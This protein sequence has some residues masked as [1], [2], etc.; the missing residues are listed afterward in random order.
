MMPLSHGSNPAPYESCAFFIRHNPSER[1]FLFFGDVE[2]D[3]LASEP[4]T[5]HVWR[6]AAPKIPHILDTIFIECSWPSGREDKQL[7]GHL[8]PEHLVQELGALALEVT[9]WRASNSNKR[10]A[11]SQ[12]NASFLR[13]RK[14]SIKAKPLSLRGALNGVRIFIIH[15]KEDMQSKYNKPMHEIITEQVKRLMDEK[16]LGATILAAEQGMYIGT[17]PSL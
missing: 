11:S 10:Y 5:I 2:P 1:E 13:K 4:K 14:K 12:S 9:R 8:T 7:Y 16:G 15:C 3:S 6:A 17:S